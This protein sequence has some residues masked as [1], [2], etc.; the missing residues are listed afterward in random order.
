TCLFHS[1]LATTM[2]KTKELSKDVTDKI[3]D[4]HK[5]GMGYKN[6]S[7]KLGE[8]ETTV[9]TKIR[10]WKKYKSQSFALAL[11]LHARSHLMGPKKTLVTHFAVKKKAHVQACLKFAIE[12]VNDS[13]KAGE[14]VM[15]SA[16]TKIE[17]FG[18]N[19]TRHVWRQRN[20]EYDPKNTISTVKHGGGNILLWGYFSAK[21]T[22]RLHCIER[23]MNGSMYR[24]ILNENLLVSART[25][26]M[27]RRWVFQH[28]NDSKHTAKATKLKFKFKKK[29]KF[30]KSLR[31]S[32]FKV[33]EWP[34]QSPDLN[35]IENLWR[36]PK[37]RV[38]RQS[39]PPSCT[40]LIGF[41]QACPLPFGWPAWRG[42]HINGRR[43]SMHGAAPRVLGTGRWS[44]GLQ[45]LKGILDKV[46]PP[47]A[48]LFVRDRM[49]S[50]P[51]SHPQR[52]L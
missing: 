16:E 5:A 27:G 12:H 51:W 33:L 28:D 30:K 46:L 35:P 31:R 10:K 18:I 7:K 20:A 8:K 19:S 9:G 49:V 25:L 34:S 22:G 50:K 38:A 14:N 41:S 40:A 42:A 1:N 15:W 44:V 29:L 4:L 39:T 23:L 36:E 45:C 43:A 3:V 26:K 24:G 11:E 21:G 32:T 47:G 52:K 2:G 17:L 6:I 37:L 13:E 48:S